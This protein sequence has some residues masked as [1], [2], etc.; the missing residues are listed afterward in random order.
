MWDANIVNLYW[1]YC[2]YWN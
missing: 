2:L 1:N